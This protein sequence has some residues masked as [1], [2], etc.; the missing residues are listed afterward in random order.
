MMLN[1]EEWFDFLCDEKIMSILLM[2]KT[3]NNSTKYDFYMTNPI[4]TSLKIQPQKTALLANSGA[5]Q[6][7]QVINGFMP[8][9]FY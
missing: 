2:D 6:E 8:L 9:I 7:K 1:V 4:K 3:P 5:V